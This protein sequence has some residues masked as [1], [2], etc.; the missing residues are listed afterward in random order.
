MAGSRN[1]FV[2]N[3]NSRN[4]LFAFLERAVNE[5]RGIV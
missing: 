2:M 1:F 4:L 3:F 5:I